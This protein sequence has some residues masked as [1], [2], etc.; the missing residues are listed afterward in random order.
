MTPGEYVRAAF[1]PED[2]PINSPK[3]SVS[4]QQVRKHLVPIHGMNVWDTLLR[5]AKFPLESDDMLT[6]LYR[7]DILLGRVGGRR[8]MRLS[9]RVL[10][11]RTSHLVL[12]GRR[13]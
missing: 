13:N 1:D 3:Q 4:E 12:M 11:L 9:K 5:Q 2:D 7:V 10:R 6:E 8:R